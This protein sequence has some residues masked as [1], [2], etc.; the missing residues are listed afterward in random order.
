MKIADVMT[1]DVR[2][3]QPD[4]NSGLFGSSQRPNVVPDVDPYA[5]NAGEYD[6]AC[7]CVPW[8]NPQAWTPASPFT[9]G[10]A[11]R[12][13]PE[14]RTPARHV[15]NLAVQKA[16]RTGGTTLTFRVEVI[17]LFNSRDL[18][19]PVIAFPQPTFG[20]ITASGGVPRTL[21]LMARAAF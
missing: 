3:I 9:F 7:R 13:D 8:L 21:Q 12:V 16:A 19:G 20:Q 14:G 6:A 18:A 15:W 2:V 10:N 11:P 1:R 17:N 4:N 5:A